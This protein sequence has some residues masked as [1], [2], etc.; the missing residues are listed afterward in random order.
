MIISQPPQQLKPQQR[1]PLNLSHDHVLS[2]EVNRST[3][4]KWLIFLTSTWLKRNEHGNISLTGHTMPV[5]AVRFGHEEEMVVAGSISGAL[6]VWD[7]EQA[8]IMRTLTGHKSSIR[9]LDFHPYGD[10]TA[11]GSL[12]ANVKVS[13]SFKF[14]SLIKC[15]QYVVLFLFVFCYTSLDYLFQGH[16]NCVNCVRFSPDGKWIASAGEDGLVKIWDLTAGKLM[17]DLNGH[18]GPV[19]IVEFHPNELLLASGSSDRT[20]KFWDLENFSMVSS[21]DGDSTPVRTIFFHPEGSCLFSGCKD[22][23]KSYSW[24]PSLCH[25]TVPIAWGEVADMAMTQNQ[26]IGASFSQTNVSLF[27]VDLQ[28]VQPF[29]GLPADQGNSS[30]SSH[31]KSFIT[32]RPPTQSTRQASVPKE[33]EDEPTNDK[34][35]VADEKESSFDIKDPDDY[36]EIF[37]PK[38]RLS[39]SPT[40]QV[41]PF[42]PPPEDG[43]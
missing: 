42:Q 35:D 1:R 9:S 20:V 34:E 23:L 12:D 5:E 13:L 43:M 31:R 39:H 21:T 30:L 16:T 6:K 29:G 37:Q 33:D 38:S 22:L 3:S 40:R 11:S 28:T 32:E 10:Y 24:E 15:K 41:E 18:T 2:T 8:K 4:R 17:T 36:R 26:L 19:N 14:S 7:L 27:V 25:D